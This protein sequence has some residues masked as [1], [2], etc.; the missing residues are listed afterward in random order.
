MNLKLIELVLDGLAS[1]IEI[2][3]MRNSE[4]AERLEKLEAGTPSVPKED[5]KEIALEDSLIDTKEVLE[6]L[7]VCYNT[8]QT[9]VGKKLLNPIRISP[10][11]IRY[12]KKDVLNYI[13]SFK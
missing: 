5:C 8:L 13:N 3:E 9:I 1:K 6:I 4:M 12:S 7:G 10:R 11:R 2:I